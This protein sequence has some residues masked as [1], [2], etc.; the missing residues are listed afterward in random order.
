MNIS[1]FKHTDIPVIDAF[2]NLPKIKQVEIVKDYQ[3]NKSFEVNNAIE[4]MRPLFFSMRSLRLDARII[5]ETL[6]DLTRFD[7][8]GNLKNRIEF[9]HENKIINLLKK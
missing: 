2:V 1:T 4:M 7:L 3:S 5:R 9:E 6:Q 8:N